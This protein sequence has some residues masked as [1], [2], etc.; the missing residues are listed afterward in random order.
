[1]LSVGFT[2]QVS[3]TAHA[4][5]LTDSIKV[6]NGM[7]SPDWPVSMYDIHLRRILWVYCPEHAGVKENGIADGLAG[8]E[9]LQVACVS[10]DLKC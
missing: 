7:G 2:R 10:E 8:K 1:M 6:K 9:P 3:Q 5:K 4:I